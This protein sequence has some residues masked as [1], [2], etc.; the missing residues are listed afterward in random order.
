MDAA[1]Q[2]L[3]RHGTQGAYALLEGEHYSESRSAGWGVSGLPFDAQYIVNPGLDLELD[4]AQLPGMR[5]QFT[6]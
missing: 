5:M 4:D 2:P 3:R 1:G 6:F